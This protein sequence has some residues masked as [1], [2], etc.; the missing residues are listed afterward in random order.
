M[1]QVHRLTA[2]GSTPVRPWRELSL[3]GPTHAGSV[4]ATDLDGQAVFC[5]LA[6]QMTGVVTRYTSMVKFECPSTAYRSP[7]ERAM[8]TAERRSVVT[9]LVEPVNPA[10][11]IFALQIQ[12]CGK[13]R[14]R[15]EAASA[16]SSWVLAE[17]AFSGS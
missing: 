10:G 14:D 4:R 12:G 15:G 3:A 1:Q 9:N 7:Y 5:G 11:D 13:G 17:I 16:C 6:H 2:E 8:R